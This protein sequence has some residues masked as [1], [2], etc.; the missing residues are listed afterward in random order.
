MKGATVRREFV[1][2]RHC[3]EIARGEWSIALAV[4]PLHSVRLPPDAKPRDRRL[5]GK[6]GEELL[7]AL[8]TPSASYLLPLISLAIQ[9]GMRRGELLSLR[10]SDVD[11]ST[12]TA[13]LTKTKNG[14]PRTV[15]LTPTALDVLGS[16]KRTDELVFPVTPTAVRLAWGRLRRRAGLDDLRLHDLRHEA[17]LRFF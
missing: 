2:L 12:R 11:L 1:I 13:R 7:A 3:F 8:T 15:P 4:N 16:L 9:T 6:E 10:W 17:I 5:R 14:H